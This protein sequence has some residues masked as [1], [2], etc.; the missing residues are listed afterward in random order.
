MHWF[1][2]VLMVYLLLLNIKAAIPLAMVQSFWIAVIV[3]ERNMS[4]Y[5]GEMSKSGRGTWIVSKVF[6]LLTHSV[7]E[8][9]CYHHQDRLNTEEEEKA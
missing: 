9:Y 4:L 5:T 3:T 6:S 1:T 2:V 7:F 8:I